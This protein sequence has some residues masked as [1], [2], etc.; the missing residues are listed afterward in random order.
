M[1]S[2][3]WC[4]ARCLPFRLR[5]LI[6][7]E[8]VHFKPPATCQGGD[9]GSSFGS[10]DSDHFHAPSILHRSQI[11][12]PL[13]KIPSANSAFPYGQQTPTGIQG[14]AG[15]TRSSSK[16]SSTPMGRR[17]GNAIGRATERQPNCLQ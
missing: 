4:A 8:K 3:W 17:S 7:Q 12:T 2:R 13:V 9:R 10:W 16:S 1:V 15:Q 6:I 5:A 14:D 11:S